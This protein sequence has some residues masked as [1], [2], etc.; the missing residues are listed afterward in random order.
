MKLS[1]FYVVDTVS[2]QF[3]TGNHLGIIFNP[4]ALETDI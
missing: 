1:T 2:V 3:W 4:L